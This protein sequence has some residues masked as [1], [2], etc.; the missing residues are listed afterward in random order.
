MAM[1]TTP[2]RSHRTP[3]RAPKISGTLSSREPWSRPVSGM[4]LPDDRPGQ[5][6]HHERDPEGGDRPRRESACGCAPTSGTGRRWPGRP[7]P[8]AGRTSSTARSG[9]AARSCPRAWP[10]RRWCVSPEVPSTPKRTVASRPEDAHDDRGLVGDRQQRRPA[11]RPVR[12]VQQWCR[13]PC[14]SA[15]STRRSAPGGGRSCG[16]GVVLRGTARSATGRPGRCRWAS[17]VA[18][19]IDEPP[20]RRPPIRMPANTTPIGLLL[21]SSA[22][23]MA[24]NPISPAMPLP[25][26]YSV[27][28]PRIW[29]APAM[30]ARPPAM[31]MTPASARLTLMPAV[32]AAFGLAPTA[33]NSNP[34]VERSSSHQTKAAAPSA[35]RNPRFSR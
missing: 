5:E 17:T 9:P 19:C 7:A 8:S 12:P 24:S 20:A 11:R 18:A 30:P 25:R 26:A 4:D 29:L 6:R 32:R 34:M 23:V 14:R 16:Q 10:G 2:A 21:P 1:L 15:P 33:R 35:R 22:T 13:L 27:A 28:P 3:D 31:I